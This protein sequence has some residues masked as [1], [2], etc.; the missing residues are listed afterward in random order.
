MKVRVVRNCSQP[1]AVGDRTHFIRA[2]SIVD[3]TCEGALPRCFEPC[4]REDRLPVAE[5]RLEAARKK[6]ERVKALPVEDRK[7]M[8]LVRSCTAEVLAAEADV[9]AADQDDAEGIEMEGP[10]ENP[11]PPILH[12]LDRDA[13]IVMALEHMDR[14][15]DE[16]WTSTGLPKVEAVELRLEALGFDPQVTRADINVARPGFDRQT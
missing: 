4:N 11:A 5:G 8:T 15:D 13:Q 2:D 12:G 16:E 3:W 7:R 14:A 1:L 9:A 6:L 10:A